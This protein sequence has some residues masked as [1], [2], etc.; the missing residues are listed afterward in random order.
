MRERAS[1]G[2][3]D[4]A[5][6]DPGLDLC[7]QVLAHGARVHVEDAMQEVGTRMAHGLQRS[8]VVAARTFDH[9]AGEGK[10]AAG[11]ADERHAIAQLAANLAHRVH[12]VAQLHRRIR[13][14]EL[15]DVAL[16]AQRPLEAR[17]FALGEAQPEAHRI[18]DRQDV[19]E[20]DRG[21]ERK[22]LERLQCH[23][24]GERGRLC[25]RQ[26]TSRL[27]A[28]RV[29]FR[30]IASG[31]SHEPDRRVLGGLPR[32]GAQQRVVLQMS[33]SVM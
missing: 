7:S 33:R 10:G 23:L 22:A 26:E 3:E 4:H 14:R 31:L 12:H 13:H 27:G 32:E 19:G 29:V 17:T 30:Q 24:G 11:E 18:R 21:I 28:R 15:G 1:P 25:Q 8:P 20:E 16:V 5:D 9:V 2:I 6:V